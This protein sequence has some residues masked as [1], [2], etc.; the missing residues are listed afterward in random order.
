MKV[1]RNEGL[2]GVYYDVN[3]ERIGEAEIGDT[4]EYYGS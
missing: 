4:N 3:N 2:Y 1:E